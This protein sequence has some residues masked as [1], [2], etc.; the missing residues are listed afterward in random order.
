MWSRSERYKDREARGNV[1]TDFACFLARSRG[2]Y[3][4][5]LPKARCPDDMPYARPFFRDDGDLMIG[6]G[7]VETKWNTRLWTGQKDYG[8]N[9]VMVDEWEKSRRALKRNTT[10]YYVFDADLSSVIVVL[11][12][13]SDKWYKESRYNSSPDVRTDISYAMCPLA[14]A[15]W[16][17]IPAEI[18]QRACD[19]GLIPQP[20]K[21]TLIDS[22]RKRREPCY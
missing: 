7:I 17:E 18:L 13:R 12:S 14:V 21:G 16:Y 6:N 15:Q 20:Y 19:R 3:A 4:R 1:A 2:Q 22:L 8:F 10:A 5:V 11:T 9:A